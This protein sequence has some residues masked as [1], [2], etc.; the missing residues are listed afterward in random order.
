MILFYN[1]FF[2]FS[3]DTRFENPSNFIT[4][5]NKR[6]IACDGDSGGPLIC[7]EDGKV[8]LHGVVSNNDF[9]MCKHNKYTYFT[10]VNKQLTFIKENVLVIIIFLTYMYLRDHPY[11]T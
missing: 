4:S 2:I 7:E 6:G 9:S 8:V 3:K 11:I 5:V 1:F 10:N